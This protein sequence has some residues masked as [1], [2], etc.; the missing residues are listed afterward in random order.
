MKL[1]SQQPVDPGAVVAARQQGMTRTNA[2]SRFEEEVPEFDHEPLMQTRMQ[3]ETVARYHVQCSVKG[4]CSKELSTLKDEVH[5]LHTLLL[6]EIR[7]QIDKNLPHPLSKD[8][9]CS[10]DAAIAVR[11]NCSSSSG[12]SLQCKVYLVASMCL[13]PLGAVL[14]SMSLQPPD[15]S[16]FETGFGKEDPNQNEVSFAALKTADADDAGHCFEFQTSWDLVVDLLKNH[17]LAKSMIYVNVLE[18]TPVHLC[19][20]GTCTVSQ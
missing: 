12:D 6:K 4:F 19:S 8:F 15:D 16:L 11:Y 18:H 9:L 13:K 14:A 3:Q 17:N 10:G 1:N 20:I 2:A 7:C 5:L